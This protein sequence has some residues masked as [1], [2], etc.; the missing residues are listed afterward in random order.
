MGVNLVRLI[1]SLLFFLKRLSIA[2]ASSLM[3]EVNESEQG[4]CQSVSPT[5]RTSERTIA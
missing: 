3:W 2:F 1:R 4:A 5:V